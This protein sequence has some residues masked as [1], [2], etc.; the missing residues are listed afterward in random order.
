MQQQRL[1]HHKAQEKNYTQ[2]KPNCDRL[3]L[4]NNQRMEKRFK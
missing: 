1:N 3:K 2:H 4:Y